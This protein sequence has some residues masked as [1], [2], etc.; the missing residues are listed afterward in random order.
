MS[1]KLAAAEGSSAEA[2]TTYGDCVFRRQLGTDQ[3]FQ[4]KL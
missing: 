1:T 3:L 4:S 2:I